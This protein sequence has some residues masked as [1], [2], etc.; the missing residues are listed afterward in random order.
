MLPHDAV[1]AVGVDA[2]YLMPTGTHIIKRPPTKLFQV[3]GGHGLR[4]LTPHTH[5]MTPAWV[6][7]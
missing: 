2:Y 7:A 4:T 3:S 1:A 6:H 5:P